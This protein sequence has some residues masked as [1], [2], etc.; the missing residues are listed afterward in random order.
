MC[1]VGQGTCSKTQ[2]QSVPRIPNPQPRNSLSHRLTPTSPPYHVYQKRCDT[3]SPTTDIDAMDYSAT[4]NDVED[5]AASPWGNS[6]ASSPRTSRTGFGNLAGEPPLSPFRG[7]SQISNGP[8]HPAAAPDDIHRPGTATTASETGESTISEAED[9]HPQADV[10]R[11]QLEGDHAPSQP[12]QHQA[13]EQPRKPAQPQYKLQAKITGLERTGKK[14]PILRFDVHVRA[15][16]PAW[17][18]S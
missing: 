10:Q 1:S 7:N 4:I 17:M 12:S 14:D 13:T 9:S 18:K 11:T 15:Q 3:S 16:L 2:Q 5:P 6:P 8:G